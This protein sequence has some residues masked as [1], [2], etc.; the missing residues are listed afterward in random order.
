[1]PLL[2]EVAVP[3]AV[4]AADGDIVGVSLGTKSRRHVGGESDA[5]IEHTEDVRL[6]EMVTNPEPAVVY[7][8]GHVAFNA[9]NTPRS[10]RDAT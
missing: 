8:A 1:M 9:T 10:S 4:G 6:A 2:L 7:T 5:T 3:E